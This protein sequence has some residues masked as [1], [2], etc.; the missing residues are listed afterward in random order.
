MEYL[1]VKWLHIVSSTLLFGT[2]I[3]SAFYL[4][5]TSLSRDVRA[6]AVVSRHVV[7][8]DWLFTA[9]TVVF[10]PLSGFYLAHLAGYPLSSGW[11]VWSVALYLVAG[12][13]W[14]PVVWLQMRMRDMA[15]ASARDGLALPA[16]YWRYLRIWTALGVP[17]FFALIVVFY[18]MTAKPA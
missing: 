8:A 14:L 13:C 5:F 6:I 3:G 11:I 15:Q 9:T 7:R 1:I 18:L 2:G 16:L 10:Q 4:L 12:A 17:A